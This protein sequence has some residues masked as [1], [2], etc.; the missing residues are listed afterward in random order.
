MKT[1]LLIKALAEDV[2]VSIPRIGGSAFKAISVSL[3]ALAVIFVLRLGLRPDLATGDAE[4][5]T[6]IKLGFTISLTLAGLYLLSREVVPGRVQGRSFLLMLL[7]L[8]ILVAGSV[9]EFGID[10]LNGWQGRLIGSNGLRCLVLIPALA[11]V[12]LVGLT[13]VLKAGAPTR[14]IM[15]GA[16]AGVAATGMAASFYALNCPDDSPL[17][18][19]V[20]YGLAMIV[21]S[22]A[23]MLAGHAFSK[24]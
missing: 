24:W 23:G 3:M 2:P 9:L 12:P 14:P 13:N 4:L 11:A 16:L 17:F 8:A 10:G 21:V 6:T 7:P 5:A 15:A 1:V 22:L 20:W 19:A 18:V